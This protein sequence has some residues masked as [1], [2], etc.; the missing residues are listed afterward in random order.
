MEGVAD[1]MTDDEEVAH[2]AQ[3]TALV[4]LVIAGVVTVAAGAAAH[5]VVMPAQDL[6]AEA[7]L[8]ADP[9]AEAGPPG[10]VLHHP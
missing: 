6:A 7:H 4:A 2:A 10:L 1:T 8:I 5:E 9:L 3:G